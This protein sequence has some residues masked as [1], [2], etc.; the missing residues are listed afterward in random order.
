[1][2]R[3]QERHAGMAELADAL[4]SGSSEGN[5]MQVQ[6]LFPAPNKHNPNYLQQVILVSEWFGFFNVECL[7]EPLN[8]ILLALFLA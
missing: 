7:Y 6:V 5:F 3:L 2:V 8:P 1:M 4:D